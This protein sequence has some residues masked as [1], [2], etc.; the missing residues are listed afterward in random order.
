M[1]TGKVYPGA[2]VVIEQD[3]ATLMVLVFRRGRLRWELPAGISEA[4]ETM[5]QTARRECAEEAYIQADI[6][7][8]IATCW[9]YSNELSAGWM[10]VFYRASLQGRVDRIPPH[11]RFEN[12][13]FIQLAKQEREG[14]LEPPNKRL[15][16]RRE[17]V[18]A[19]GFVELRELA[20]Q[21]VHP[22]HYEVLQQYKSPGAKLPLFMAKDADTDYQFY[23]SEIPLFHAKKG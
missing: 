17:D 12:V 9:H 1:F 4:G 5:E 3:N 6:G 10:G 23:S 18:L 14:V 16:G 8:V 11:K 13:D 2:G 19:I 22:I 7:G 21:R 15:K 20:F